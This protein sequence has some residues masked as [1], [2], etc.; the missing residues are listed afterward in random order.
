MAAGQCRD[1]ARPMW[2]ITEGAQKRTHARAHQAGEQTR[3]RF[4]STG[5]RRR[6]DDWLD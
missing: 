6:A 2:Q 4:E 3:L 5:H 1:E